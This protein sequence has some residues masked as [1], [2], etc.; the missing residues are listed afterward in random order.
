MASDVCP[1][2]HLDTSSSNSWVKYVPGATLTE[3]FRRAL[4]V[5][6]PDRLIFGTDSSFFPPGWRRV[7]YG[8]QRTVLDE[9]GI[10]K[11]AAAKIFGGN[12]DRIFPL[13]E[14]S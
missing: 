4:N 1:T 13:R 11:D 10:E 6:G 7:I 8:A 5:I 3:V 9:L 14:P 2:I 12:F